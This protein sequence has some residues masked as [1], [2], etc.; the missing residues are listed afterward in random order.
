MEWQL[1]GVAVKKCHNL[2]KHFFFG[3]LCTVISSGKACGPDE[4]QVIT[5]T[6]EI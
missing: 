3:I 4:I 5:A 6:G 1:W 2:F